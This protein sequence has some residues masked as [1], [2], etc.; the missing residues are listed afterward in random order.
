MQRLAL[1]FAFF[2]AVAQATTTP[3]MPNPFEPDLM[4]TLDAIYGA[5]NYIRI[6]D[7][8]EQT[9]PGGDYSIVARSTYSSASQS[10]GFC[11]LCD[12]SD[13]TFLDQL[14]WID[15]VFSI[16]M[17][18]GGSST[19]TVPTRFTWLDYAVMGDITHMVYSD[20]ALNPGGLD[21]MVT[22]AVVGQP[23]TYLL[24]FEDWYRTDGADTDF[25]DFLF[26]VTYH[27]QQPAIAPEPSAIF[28]L[29]GGLAALFYLR[30]R[31]A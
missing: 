3:I 7:D 26:E 30:R 20:P 12:G 29:A 21:Q 17:T 4:Q 9:W 25:N 31:R 10:L 24:A 6:D 5:G 8:I 23:N 16:P 19:V 28:S 13:N 22:F 2:G 1:F 18:L 27:S 14:I 11:I 15:G